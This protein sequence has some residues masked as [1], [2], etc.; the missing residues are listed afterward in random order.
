LGRFLQ[1]DPLGYIDTMNIYAY[2][3][4]NPINKTDPLGLVGY[5]PWPGHPPI[6]F[7]QQP[8][9]SLNLN[10][11]AP[12][13]YYPIMGPGTW[14][15]YPGYSSPENPYSGGSGN[16]PYAPI[17]AGFYMPPNGAASD[18][19]NSVAVGLL[20]GEIA[21]GCA[22]IGAQGG[23]PGVIIGV[24]VGAFI[25]HMIDYFP[26]PSEDDSETSSPA[27]SSSSSSSSEQN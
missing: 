4:N 1:P 12:E 6:S 25:D 21:V 7:P 23:L 20:K 14:N 8:P 22:L 17:G 16:M 26:F 13:K 11:S 15:P 9:S 24:G 27:S 3:G 2:C 5:S 10:G 18:I 19:P